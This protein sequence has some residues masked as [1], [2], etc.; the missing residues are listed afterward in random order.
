MLFRFQIAGQIFCG[1]SQKRA[2]VTALSR[3]N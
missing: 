3:V 1:F 2:A